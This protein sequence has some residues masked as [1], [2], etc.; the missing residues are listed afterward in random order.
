MSEFR[1]NR[2]VGWKEYLD[3]P[4]LGIFRL[5]AKVDTGAAH[6]IFERRMKFVLFTHLFQFAKGVFVLK[7]FIYPVSEYTNKRSNHSIKF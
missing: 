6:C 2:L 4:E 1:E 5:K 7:Q 3:L